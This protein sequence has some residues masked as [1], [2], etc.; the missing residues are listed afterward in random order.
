MGLPPRRVAPTKTARELALKL[1]IHDGPLSLDILK[2]ALSVFAE[3][4][5][6]R[7]TLD[8]I[9]DIVGTAR[10]NVLRYY[11]TKDNLFNAV[12]VE[13]IDQIQ[14]AYVEAMEKQDGPMGHLD[15]LLDLNVK[16]TEMLKR[17]FR[18]V[19]EHAGRNQDEIS[20]KILQGVREFY[21]YEIELFTAAFS[22]KIPVL[23][24]LN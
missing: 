12:L 16:K 7:S 10:P 13:A 11:K 23:L 20:P 22:Q 24:P 2:A 5:Y 14:S 19:I 18:I 3:K 1:R 6:S 4:G 8:S 21:K 9:G 15:G 17:A